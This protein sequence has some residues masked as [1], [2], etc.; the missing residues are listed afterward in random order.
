M[1][2]FTVREIGGRF[3]VTS[4]QYTPTWVH[5]TTKA[6]TPVAHTLAY[7]PGTYRYGSGGLVAALRGPGHPARVGRHRPE[8]HSLA[9]AAV[10]RA[11]VR[12]PPRGC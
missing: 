9:G 11:P 6:A 1:V 7:G 12:S 3:V 5:P 10:P 4:T 8:P 2:H